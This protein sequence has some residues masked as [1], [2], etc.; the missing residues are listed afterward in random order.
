MKFEAYESV[1]TPGKYKC[2]CP[3]CKPCEDGSVNVCW[4]SHNEIIEMKRDV[5]GRWSRVEGLYGKGGVDALI[6]LDGDKSCVSAD[7]VGRD[8]KRIVVRR[9]KEGSKFIKCAELTLPENYR[10]DG[11]A[12]SL[13]SP[14][15]WSDDGKNLHM[16]TASSAGYVF[17]ADSYDGGR[18]WN[19]PF[20]LNVPNPGSDIALSVTGNRFFLLC[21]AS[22]SKQTPLVLYSS[23]TAGCTYKRENVIASGVGE[24]TEPFI[25]EENRK[26][27]ITF[28]K[29]EKEVML[30]IISL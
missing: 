26:L 9:R 18:H 19:T 3:T 15:L 17:R 29:N 5:K 16:L 20:P 27:Y 23:G 28:V 2:S 14:R 11:V 13:S 4:E 25:Y 24:F 10:R 8:G 30:V 1:C 22:G 12:S 7:A 21:P 6:C